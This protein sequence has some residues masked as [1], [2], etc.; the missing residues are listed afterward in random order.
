[1]IATMRED[2]RSYT[3]GDPHGDFCDCSVQPWERTVPSVKAAKP[4][5]V[6]TKADAEEYRDRL[7]ALVEVLPV[8]EIERRYRLSHSTT[9]A[10]LD[11][12]TRA[13]QP[14]TAERLDAALRAHGM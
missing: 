11:G 12:T 10:I 9:R 8:S 1:M 6:R 7:A 13:V 3:L 4:R 2:G 14:S 5:G